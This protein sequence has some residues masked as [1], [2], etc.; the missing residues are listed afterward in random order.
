MSLRDVYR[1]MRNPITPRVVEI[2]DRAEMY[3]YLYDFVNTVMRKPV[4][5]DTSHRHPP[6]QQLPRTR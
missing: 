1:A 2:R 3:V 4:R 5:V 6:M